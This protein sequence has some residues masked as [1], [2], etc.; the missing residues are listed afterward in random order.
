MNRNSFTLI[1]LLVVV[2]IIAV[3]VA[4]LLPSLN[5]ARQQAQAMVC[6]SNQKQVFLAF[7]N[8]SQD[9]IGYGPCPA[10]GW[11]STWVIDLINQRYLP[12]KVIPGNRIP[13]QIY[14][15]VS[16]PIW[17]GR[18]SS[19]GNYWVGHS[20]GEIVYGYWS[21]ANLFYPNIIKGYPRTQI[22]QDGAMVN[23]DFY[24]SPTNC[25]LLTDSN[26]GLTPSYPYSYSRVLAHMVGG[27]DDRIP[28][29]IH[30]GKVSIC[31]YDGHCNLISPQSLL[32]DFG[33]EIVID[34][35]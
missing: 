9:N 23:T 15:I 10:R 24:E 33:F 17:K 13:K 26:S 25:M 19:D 8:Y 3:L 34:L 4:I 20:F 21:Y 35:R 32:S 16:C 11:I 12:G 1:E 2:A 6:I 5:S 7:S 14:Q 18:P 31:F 22:Y 28:I 29:A 27:L 30:Q